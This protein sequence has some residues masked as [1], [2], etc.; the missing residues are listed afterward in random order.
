MMK[1]YVRQFGLDWYVIVPSAFCM[2][3]T[4]VD[5]PFE[6]QSKVK[7]VLPHVDNHSYKLQ[8]C[9]QRH[10]SSTSF[11][12]LGRKSLNIEGEARNR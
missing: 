3:S 9:F 1:I 6:R 7:T 10:L 4:A 5:E 2:T 11:L 8:D 12:L